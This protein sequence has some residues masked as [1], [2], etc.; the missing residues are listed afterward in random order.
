MNGEA[1]GSMKMVAEQSR[2]TESDS[3]GND[4]APG[5]IEAVKGIWHERVDASEH[6]GGNQPKGR[7]AVK[8]HMEEEEQDWFHKVRTGL[9]RTTLQEI[10]ARMI[11]VRKTAPRSPAQPS[12]LKKVV[13][14]VLA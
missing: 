12:A 1:E 5:R 7:R 10:G 4:S 13:D 6:L 14:A 8:H 11:E 2:A 3:R 9:S